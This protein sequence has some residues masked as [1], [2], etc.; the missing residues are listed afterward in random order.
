MPLRP[1]HLR[2]YRQ[3]AEVLVRHGFGAIV[4][5]LGLDRHLD[6]PRRLLRRQPPPTDELTAATHIRRAL[7]E[8]GGTF[9]KLGQILSTRP[10]LLPPDFIAELSQLQDNVPPGPWEPI[11]ASI[12][13]ELGAPLGQFFLAVD[14]TPIA[15]ASLA[16][17][18]AALLTDGTQVVVK[19]QRPGIDRIVYTDLEILQDLARLAQDRLPL[20][21]LYD[22]VEL[23]DEFSA[24]LRTELDYRHEGRNSDRFRKNF[25]TE[26][27]LYVPKVYWNYSTR[28]ILVQERIAGI[29]ISDIE[30]LEAA[31]Y[32][33][34][35]LAMHAARFVI[36]EVLEDGFFH[37]D[38]HPGNMVI[39]PGEV[40]GLIDFGT[41]G[42]LAPSD[43]A[44][45]VRLYIVLIQFDIVGV[46]DQLVR[47]GIADLRLDQL[48]LQRDLRRL[49]LKYHGLPLKDI[50]VGELLREIEPI[51]Y[52]HQL[53]V[54][55]D[56]WLLMKTLVIM[57][58][59]GKNLAPEFDVFAASEPYVRRF[60]LRMWLPSTWGPSVL[61]SATGWTDLL[62]NFPRQ[63][64]NILSRM[65]RGELEVQVRMPLME[66]ATKQMNHIAN[67]IVLS[68]LLAALI[69]AL[70]LLIPILDLSTWPWSFLTWIIVLGFTVASILAIW[71]ILSILRSNSRI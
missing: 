69:I 3:I 20:G 53:R 46:V 56:F 65:E 43:R 13:A 62:A 24:A 8:L 12:E 33:R 21:N 4:T 22:L 29:K 66:Q 26:T 59:V 30:A 18:Y 32:D 17:V 61:R 19:V 11:Q 45:L 1:R 52:N 68:I 34:T 51:V 64:T 71:L 14:P 25:A 60:L 49:L 6:L 57:E 35:R 58:G 48:A 9:V 44:N 39:M 31:G 50:A 54:P 41:V 42:Y 28:R 63:S 5:Q 10:D 38:P 70:A 47:M 2:R 36:K 16:Q 37:A 15:S 55:S 7:E 67:R 23:A 27:H 40:I